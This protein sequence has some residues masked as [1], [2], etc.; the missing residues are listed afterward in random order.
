M[1]S[2]IAAATLFR[3]LSLAAVLLMSACSLAICPSP[4]PLVPPDPQAALIARGRALFFNETFG[5][6]GRTC[7]TCHREEN[8]FSIDPAFIA[9]LPRDDPLFVA[10]FN[11]DLRENF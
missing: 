3:K 7:G 9:T 11:P 2:P 10:E 5:G 6:N 1:L 4:L 8:N